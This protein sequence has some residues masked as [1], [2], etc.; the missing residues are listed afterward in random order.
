MQ[1]AG[2]DILARTALASNQDMALVLAKA[3]DQGDD[4]L[5]RGALGDHSRNR[6]LALDDLLQPFVLALQVSESR[7]S[8]QGEPQI[9]GSDRLD[10]VVEGLVADRIDRALERPEGGHEND[11]QLRRTGEGFRD[12]FRPGHA[13][14]LHIHHDGVPRLLGDSLQRLAPIHD[15]LDRVALAF[16]DAA[17]SFEDDRVVIH[18][19]NP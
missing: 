5:H 11:G 12:H 9:R 19:Q 18:H 17:K 3:P 15:G 16:G 8:L 13:R 2:D 6:V 4:L 10:Q 7:R 14:K 1:G